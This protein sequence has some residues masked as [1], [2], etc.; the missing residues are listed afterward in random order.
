MAG[1]NY[2]LALFFIELS[3]KTLIFLAS[4]PKKL[5]TF[6]WPVLARFFFGPTFGNDYPS[7]L[8]LCDPT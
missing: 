2:F 3:Q 8:A 4:G 5:A 7:P 6:G 1:Q